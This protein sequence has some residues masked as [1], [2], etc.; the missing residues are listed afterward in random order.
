MWSQDDEDGEEGGLDTS[1]NV[2]TGMRDD[3]GE[4]EEEGGLHPQ[5][6]DAYW[7]QRRI[8]KAFEEAGDPADADKSQQLANDVFVLLQVGCFAWPSRAPLGIKLWG[9]AARRR[10][11][12]PRKL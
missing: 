7:L 3:G 5:D 8:A 12:S 9:Y 6:I 2:M 4:A 1:G 11:M 10:G